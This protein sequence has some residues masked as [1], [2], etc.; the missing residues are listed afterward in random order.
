[1]AYLA[2]CGMGLG[3]AGR[4]LAVARRL[5][6]AGVEVVFSSYG[7]AV[8][9]VERCGLPCLRTRL[10]SYEVDGEGDV[11][12]RGTVAKSPVNIYRF[13]R[14]VGDELY[15]M[16][17][18][19]PV[20]V[21]S[22]SRLSTLLAAKVY[23][24][25]SILVLSQLKVIIPV[26]APSSQKLKVK[27]LAEEGLYRLLERLWRLADEILIP[28]F[29]PPY[30]IARANMVEGPLPPKVR[31]I[32]P[33]IPAWPDELPLREEVREALGV[34]GR[35]VVAS[36]TG[37]GGEGRALMEEFLRELAEC[38][39]PSDVTV[40][41]SRGIPLSSTA[42]ERVRRGVYVCD[43]L[44]NRHLYVRAAD[45]L[46]T[47]GG[48]TSVMEAVVF[49]VPAVHVVRRTHTERLGISMTTEALG[50]AR[51]HVVEEG[52][53]LYAALQ[54]ALSDEAREAAQRLAREVSGLKGDVTVA[55]RALA[56]A[57]RAL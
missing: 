34:R 56:L 5:A 32:G 45:A 21:V 44:P 8:D 53:D 13:A 55:E 17:V 39:L 42:L 4:M 33:T 12:V 41:V 38:E 3:H 23:G 40:I 7:R 18:L 35:L 29:P 31:F 28:D 10:I 9:M 50:V 11:D 6:N 52:R 2:P 57:G 36:F 49:G 37:V 54:W 27:R 19:K 16:G 46:V 43:W 20:V 30:T 51:T 14:Q 48:H 1:M 26:K 24:I 15:Y 25:P 47:H 22:D